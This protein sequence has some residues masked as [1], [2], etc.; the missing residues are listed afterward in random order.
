MRLRGKLRVMCRIRPF[1]YNE[2]NKDKDCEFIQ[3]FNECIAVNAVNQKKNSYEFDYVFSQRSN[4][5]D[6][7]EE[8]SMLINNF[9]RDHNITII[10]YGQSKSGKTYTIEGLNTANNSDI[11]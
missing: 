5:S 1:L 10:S 3:A 6:V 7:Y 11:T 4:Q 9:P 2:R 8:V